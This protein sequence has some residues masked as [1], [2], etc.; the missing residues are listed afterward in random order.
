MFILGYRHQPA[1]GRQSQTAS[2]VCAAPIVHTIAY[3]EIAQQCVSVG[4]T[5]PTNLFLQVACGDVAPGR[6]PIRTFPQNPQRIIR[7][8]RNR[9]SVEAAVWSI[10][11]QK[12][13]VHCFVVEIEQPEA[14]ERILRRADCQRR[15][16]D[17][18]QPGSARNRRHSYCLDVLNH[19]PSRDRSH[20][21]P[22]SQNGD[23]RSNHRFHELLRVRPWEDV[24]PDL[25][26]DCV[27]GRQPAG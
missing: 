2:R 25:R 6:L 22:A 12:L 13:I 17:D 14:A 27:R 4:F 26:C 10:G 3:A 7:H 8:R 24:V 19:D 18:P 1:V 16:H 21:G 23:A 9:R 20:S 15:R 5:H 11:V